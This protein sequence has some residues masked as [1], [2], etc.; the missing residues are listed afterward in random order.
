MALE[1]LLQ[2][3]T[4]ALIGASGTPGKWGYMMMRTLLD[5]GFGGEIAAV[6]GR[7]GEVQGHPAYPTVADLPWAPDVALVT[8][9]REAC[10]DAVEAL[11]ARGCR[12][13]VLYAAGFAELG[14]EGARL[15]AIDLNP[16]RVS[17]DG[18][19]I[20]DARVLLVS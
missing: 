9:G 10:V 11:A 6:N 15:Q 16:V 12:H 7:G 5:G 19:R 18:V 4:V 1:R 17:A 8:V 3:A 2:P 14:A 13:A 20:L